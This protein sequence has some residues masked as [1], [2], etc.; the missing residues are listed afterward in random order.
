MLELKITQQANSSTTPPARL[1][2]KPEPNLREQCNAIVLR[3]DTQLEGPKGASDEVESQKEYDKDVAPLPSEDE[4]KEQRK[5][6]RLKES[7][8]LPRKPYMPPSHSYKGL[9]KLRLNHNLA[10]FLIC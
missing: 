3:S 10:S 9:L 5:C 6:E 7:R 8:P 1:L 2:S 4:P